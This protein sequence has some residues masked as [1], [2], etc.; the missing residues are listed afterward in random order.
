VSKRYKDSVII[1]L[2]KNA[3]W[4]HWLLLLRNDVTKERCSKHKCSSSVVILK[5]VTKA[6]EEPGND[7]N[8]TACMQC[9]P[10][11]R[12]TITIIDSKCQ[13]KVQ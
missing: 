1:M 5:Y 6:G 4:L 10:A 7:G 8:D 3:L 11:L 2:I 13:W 9:P 12:F